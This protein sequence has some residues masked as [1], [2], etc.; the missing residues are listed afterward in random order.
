[1]MM[2]M[3]P[4]KDMFGGAK[5]GGSKTGGNPSSTV[6]LAILVVVAVERSIGLF[7]GVME[8]Q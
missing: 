2:I 5:P 1:M 3:M 6:F 7:L 4:M 8:G